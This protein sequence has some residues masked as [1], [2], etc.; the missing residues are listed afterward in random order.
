[1]IALLRLAALLVGGGFVLARTGAV[2][3]EAGAGQ[4]GYGKAALRCRIVGLRPRRSTSTTSKR[5][6]RSG[7]RPM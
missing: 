6:G 7:W 2:R 4:G 3:P 5:Q 1:M